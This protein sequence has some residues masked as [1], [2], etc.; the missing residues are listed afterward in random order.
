VMSRVGL[1]NGLDG[2][3]RL[4]GVG[5]VGRAGFVSRTLRMRMK[6]DG[7]CCLQATTSGKT[8]IE[9]E[10]SEPEDP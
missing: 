2:G 10:T 4:S 5:V 9:H 6:S 7:M 3:P 8:A 1:A